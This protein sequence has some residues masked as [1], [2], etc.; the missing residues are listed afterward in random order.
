VIDKAAVPA[1]YVDLHSHSTASDGSRSP[2]QVIAAAARAGL[3]A[4]ALTD[5]DSVSGIPEAVAEG[6]R[7]GVRV[8]TGTELSAH[9]D[10]GHEIHLL[11]LHL[12]DLEPLERKLASLRDVRRRRAEAMVE[13]L[14]A[15]GLPVS[16]ESVLEQARGGALGRPHVARALVHGRL[17][18]DFREAFERYLGNGRAAYVEK[19]RLAVPDAIKL[20]HDAGGIAVLAHPGPDATL[21]SLSHMKDVGLDGVE[22]R[23]PSHL[24]EQE[25]AISELADNLGLLPS[26][27]SDWHGASDGPRVLGCMNVPREWLDRQ[28]AASAARQSA[29]R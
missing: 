27:G 19:E 8:V 16:M 26:G 2:A 20:V 24:P 28:D 14:N 11:G 3:A 9:D 10:D 6:E 4:I 15:L 5:H 18:K 7:H 21:Q 17:V 13:K 25:R 12:A 23:H 29:G 22:V 1:A